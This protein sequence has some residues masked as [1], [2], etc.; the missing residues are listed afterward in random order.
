MQLTVLKARRKVKGLCSNKWSIHLPHP[1]RVVEGYFYLLLSYKVQNGQNDM[2]D[3]NDLHCVAF[4][5]FVHWEDI[6]STLL[7]RTQNTKP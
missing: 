5:L 3:Q 7:K 4:R 2:N 6:T 1:L